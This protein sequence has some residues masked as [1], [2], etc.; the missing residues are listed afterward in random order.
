MTVTRLVW[1]GSALAAGDHLL[2]AA[3]SHHARVARVGPGEPVEV[4]DL[5]GTVGEGVLLGWEGRRARLRIDHLCRERGEPPGALV[6]GLGVLHTQAFDWAVEKLT[7]LGATRI[8]PLLC[9]RVQGRR[10]ELRIER[11]RRLSDAAVAQCGRSRPAAIDRVTALEE[12]LGGAP[13]VRLVADFG[14]GP[15]PTAPVPVPGV[16]ILV[17]PEGGFTPSELAAAAAAG[18]LPLGLGPRTLR[19][20]TAAVGAVAVACAWAGWL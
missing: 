14:A 15:L 17:G 11:W 20:E 7:E 6:V 12:F 18:F 1:R 3:V 9:E 10:H 16:S 19:A 2:P 5:D 4:L 13:G 8:V